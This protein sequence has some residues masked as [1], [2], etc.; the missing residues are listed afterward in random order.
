MSG[1]DDYDDEDEEDINEDFFNMFKGLGDPSKIFGNFDPAKLFN[2][3]EFQKMFKE[4]F[5]QLAR[6]LPKELQ[7]LSPEE[8][9]REFMKKG[10]IMYGFNMGFGPDGKP[11]M[12]SFG[13]L[14]KEP[15]SGERK[16]RKTR[17]P[18]VEVNEEE[19]QIILIA[20]MPGVNKEDIELNATNTSIT[21]S[22]EKI[23]SGRSY[24]KEIDLPAPINSDYA[25]ARYTNGILEVKLKKIKE[26]G[27]SIDIE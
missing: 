14:E 25:K 12:N 8:I 13:N 20:E 1:K 6:N 17:E 26:K 16:V 21:I 7:G 23:V 2:S 9:T 22:T 24:F 27:K 11:I 19:D 15:I 5:K 10:P 4:I 18:L 3:K